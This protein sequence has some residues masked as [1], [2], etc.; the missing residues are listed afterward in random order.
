MLT[1]F[2]RILLF[3]EAVEGSEGTPAV[4]TETPATPPAEKPPVKAPD[5]APAEKP[6][7][8][9]DPAEGFRKLLDKHANDGVRLAEKLYG[10]L[11][12]LREKNRE[13][14]GKVPGE[15]QT[16]LGAEDVTLF[17]SYQILG[18]PED[19]KQAV[20]ERD[21]FQSE[22]ENLKREKVYTEA[23]KLTEF[24]PSVF[25]L[26]AEREGLEIAITDGKDK[27]GK[28]ARVAVVVGAGEPDKDG[29]PTDQPLAMYAAR[30]WGDL[31]PAL[32]LDA[33]HGRPSGGTPTGA[34]GQP[35]PAVSPARA[36]PRRNPF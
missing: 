28:P 22:A 20:Y 7:V 19:L 9:S 21:Q 3:P 34:N 30:H 14:R 25:A 24:N 29:K 16:V 33:T 35:R 5:Q 31:L 1:S 18:K 26:K 8:A 27:S 12:D 15:G 23:A 13:L 10:E 17:R 36:T 4:T 2:Y 32:R 6:V 11:H